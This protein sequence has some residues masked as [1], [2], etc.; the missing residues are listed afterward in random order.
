MK[1]TE[2]TNRLTHEPKDTTTF[3][4]STLSDAFNVSEIQ[5]SLQGAL[6]T[7]FIYVL[8][9]T[10]LISVIAI[11]SN[12]AL[13]IV[14]YKEPGIR[15]TNYL[16]IICLLV[17]DLNMAIMYPT[18]CLVDLEI[19]NDNPYCFVFVGIIVAMNSGNCLYLLALTVE[20]YII[21]SKPLKAAYI[22]TDARVKI[23]A[24]GILLY[25]VLLGVITLATPVT[26][27]DHIDECLLSTVVT[28]TFWRWIVYISG[29]CPLIFMIGAYINIFFI[30]RR[31]IRDIA[32]RDV[33]VAPNSGN[34]GSADSQTSTRSELPIIRQRYCWKRE[35]KAALHLG[36]IVFY[37]ALSWVP[38][39]VILVKE[40][41]GDNVSSISYALCHAVVY[42]NIAVNPFVFGFGNREIRQALY[43][44]FSL[45]YLACLRRRAQQQNWR[46]VSLISSFLFCTIPMF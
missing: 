11:A 33:D 22:L 16:F 32:E 14:F 13:L 42:T 46:R 15:T 3:T 9:F 2:N 29:F 20:R 23:A 31:H 21:I 19:L 34:V 41:S 35:V 10:A 5:N 28:S 4:S 27:K 40:M 24:F 26:T 18:M 39:A 44:T 25:S 12:L 30:V 36:F 45:K 7:A 1:M 37:C 17:A 43:R 38:Y 8:V 6:N